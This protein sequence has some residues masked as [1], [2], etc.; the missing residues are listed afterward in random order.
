MNQTIY[1]RNRNRSAR[2][3]SSAIAIS[4]SILLVRSRRRRSPAA[5]GHDSW[6]QIWASSARVAVPLTSSIELDPA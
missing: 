4:R 2:N 6:Y 1:N 5:K 3:V